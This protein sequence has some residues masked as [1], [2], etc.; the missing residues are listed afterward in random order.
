MSVSM[1]SLPEVNG[2]T[3]AKS[4]CQR[5][6]PAVSLPSIVYSSQTSLAGQSSVSVT[7]SGLPVT[8]CP[9]LP[10]AHLGAFSQTFQDRTD[11]RSKGAAVTSDANEQSPG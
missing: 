2:P 6:V 8:T 9:T 4:G 11:T 3:P 7:K 5:E 10:D 1:S